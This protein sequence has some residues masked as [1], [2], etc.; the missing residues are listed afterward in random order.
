MPNPQKP[1]T[2]LTGAQVAFLVAAAAVLLGSL[3]WRMFAAASGATPASAPSGSAGMLPGSTS[4]AD[5]SSALVP[6]FTAA[7]VFAIIGFAV[8]FVVR[9]IVLGALVIVGIVAIAIL[10]LSYTHV[11]TIPWHEITDWLNRTLLDVKE[12][13]PPTDSLLRH[14]PSAGTASLGFV[15]GLKRK[16]GP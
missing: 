5:G 9:K 10:A 13:L 16:T 15:L 6:Y 1:P 12:K 2:Y 8:G 3:A 4:S 11:V 14:V 7:S